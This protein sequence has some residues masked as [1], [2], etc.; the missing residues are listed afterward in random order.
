MNR[1]INYISCYVKGYD[2]KFRISFAIYLKTP[3]WRFYNC[4][5]FTDLVDVTAHL[6]CE[7]FE[8]YNCFGNFLSIKKNLCWYNYDMPKGESAK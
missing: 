3:L 8:D 1:T 5:S 6:G 4:E 2:L 7:H